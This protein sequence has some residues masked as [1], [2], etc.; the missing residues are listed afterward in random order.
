MPDSSSN[1][2]LAW[3]ITIARPQSTQ[4][5]I[6]AFAYSRYLLVVY[7]S[8]A[9][10][11][12]LHSSES[13]PKEQ[14]TTVAPGHAKMHSKKPRPSGHHMDRNFGLLLSSPLHLPHPRFKQ[15][16]DPTGGPVCA[17]SATCRP[18]CRTATHSSFSD[19]ALRSRTQEECLHGVCG[20]G[21]IIARDRPPPSTLQCARCLPP[22]ASCK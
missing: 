2:C 19:H 11:L 13:I 15:L 9:T 3:P 21:L 18:F 20:R 5:M 7:A 1:P 12:P 16:H 14:P 17:I 8:T 4:G 10:G 22:S 6:S